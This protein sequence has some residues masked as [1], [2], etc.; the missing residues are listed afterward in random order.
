MEYFQRYADF[1]N[2]GKKF[3]VCI[4]NI[5]NFLI[6]FPFMKIKRKY[7]TGMGICASRILCILSFFFNVQEC[8]QL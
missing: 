7:F 3:M 4:K 5:F 6:K 2:F 1:E 8:H